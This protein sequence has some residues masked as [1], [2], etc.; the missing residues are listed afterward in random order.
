MKC[1]ILSAGYATRLYPLTKET[2]KPLLEVAGKS[3]LERLLDKIDHVCVATNSRFAQPFQEWVGKYDYS[4]PLQSW[5]TVPHRT[6]T[7]LVLLATSNMWWSKQL[8]QTI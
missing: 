4:N 3:I 8:L 7:A 5:T 1:V 6:R 2:P